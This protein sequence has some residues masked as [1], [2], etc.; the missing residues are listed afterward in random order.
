[1]CAI[2]DA[3]VSGEVFGD[4]KSEAGQFFYDWLTDTRKSGK[5]VIGGKIRQELGVHTGFRGWLVQS[6]LAGRAREVDDRR[7]DSEAAVLQSDGSC[8]SNDWYV[9]GLARVSGALLLFSNDRALQQDFRNREIVGGRTRGQVYTTLVN[10][11]V[12]SSHRSLLNRND[13]CET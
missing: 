11:D 1:M 5:L 10:K 12:R 2:V 13:L 8:Q 3:N 4:N 6:L 7:V 9:L